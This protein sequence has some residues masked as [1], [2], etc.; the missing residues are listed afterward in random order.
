MA[1]AQGTSLQPEALPGTLGSVGLPGGEGVRVAEKAQVTLGDG[2]TVRRDGRELT[3]LVAGGCVC[4][5]PR[6]SRKGS[7]HQ[8]SALAEPLRAL[9]GQ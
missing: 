6:G 3:V 9:Q 1:A 4:G 2:S 8:V 5:R 7:A